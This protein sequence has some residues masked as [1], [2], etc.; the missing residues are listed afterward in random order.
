MSALR[1]Q[2]GPF[3]VGEI[4]LV[5][6]DFSQRLAPGETISSVT[7]QVVVLTGTDATPAATLSGGA[8][9]QGPLV[10][11]MLA[12]TVSNVTYLL[13]LM[14]STSTGRAVPGVCVIPVRNA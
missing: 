7:R 1:R 9:V 13:T 11:Q 10:R 3:I 14:A 6:C 12:P 5:E 4:D 2:L 8:Q